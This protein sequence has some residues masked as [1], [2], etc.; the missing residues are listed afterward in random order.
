MAKTMYDT[1]KNLR[2]MVS[3]NKVTIITAKARPMTPAE[4]HA[5]T[6]G[7]FVI[8]YIGMLK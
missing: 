4:H 2:K 1:I 8:D 7:P 6:T 3:R 5:A